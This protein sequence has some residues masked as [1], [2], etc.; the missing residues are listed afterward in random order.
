MRVAR[1]SRRKIQQGGDGFARKADSA[2]SALVN[3]YLRELLPKWPL[4]RVEEIEGE[5][6]REGTMLCFTVSR[7]VDVGLCQA[8]S[9]APLPNP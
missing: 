1:T 3:R 4:W 8:G 7:D 6:R 2:R 9:L 5:Q